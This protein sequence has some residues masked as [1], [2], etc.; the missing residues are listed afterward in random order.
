MKPANLLIALLAITAF[1]ACNNKPEAQPET[2]KIDKRTYHSQEV[3]WTMEVPAGWELTDLQRLKDLDKKGM[4]LLE[5][6]TG[7]T[8]PQA[9]KMK[10]LLAFQKDRFNMFQSTIEPYEE[11]APGEWRANT[12]MLKKMMYQT[13][14]DQGIRVDSS[15]TEVESISGIVFVTFEFTLYKPDGDVLIQ[16]RMYTQLINGYDMGINLSY[17]NEQNEQEMTTALKK[18]VFK[19]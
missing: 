18:S 3:G 10:H 6:S 17:N 11:T 9:D 12:D 15:I 1:V 14:A 16:Q 8:D 19:R 2:G 13:F 4:E 7:V 5:K